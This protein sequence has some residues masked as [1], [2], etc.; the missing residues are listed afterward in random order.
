MTLAS[1]IFSPPSF[2]RGDSESENPASN[3]Q[4]NF[5]KSEVV[6]SYSV[7]EKLLKALGSSTV[8]PQSRLTKLIFTRTG[9]FSS[10][11]FRLLLHDRVR[12]GRWAFKSVVAT[13]MCTYIHCP[14]SATIPGFSLL[15]YRVF[16]QRLPNTRAE[17]VRKEE[18]RL[19]D[20]F[21][22]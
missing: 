12:I 3:P 9:S 11:P 21:H 20:T 1:W 18:L 8:P 14:C 10:C 22:Y 4:F 16:L 19:W 15:L 13:Q 17:D 5:K 6:V 2:E 7:S